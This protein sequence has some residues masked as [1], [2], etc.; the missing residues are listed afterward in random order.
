MNELRLPGAEVVWTDAAQGHLASDWAD[1]PPK[2]LLLVQVHGRDVVRA[3]AT[4]GQGVEADA[5]VTADPDVVLGIKTADCA[6]IAIASPHGVAAIH[7]GWPGVVAGV[8]SNAVAALR[9]L[10]DGPLYAGL[11]PCIHACCYEFGEVDLDQVVAATDER[12]RATARSG[13]MS[14]DLPAA[15][16]WQLEKAGVTLQYEAPECTACSGQHF[17]YRKTKTADRQVMFVRRT[18]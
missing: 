11:G 18:S 2:W 3:G 4:T 6:P 17:S 14:L 13:R 15:V 8:I 10:G 7:S 12:V 9:E 5:S 1:R 16:R